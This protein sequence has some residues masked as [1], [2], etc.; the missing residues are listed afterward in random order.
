VMFANEMDD[1]CKSLGVEW[2][3]TKKIIVADNR[4]GKTHFDVTSVRGFGGKCL[5]PETIV[6]T[7]TGFKCMKD[8]SVGEK[9]FDGSGFTEIT[10]LGNRFVTETIEIVSRGR[11]IVGSA[12][13]I[14]LVYSEEG[15]LIETP[16]Q[17]ITTDCW[18]SIP[19]QKIKNYI[20]TVK[21]GKK[22]N[23]N[24]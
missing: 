15:K 19:R 18:I 17:N 9:I 14:H 24:I 1:L 16:L 10:A 22:P 20:K 6:Q 7:E 21:L 3:E 12:D 5:I 4:I 11:K 13:H 23:N 2:A 8:L